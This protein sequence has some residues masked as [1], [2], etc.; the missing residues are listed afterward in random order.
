MKTKTTLYAIFL[1]ACLSC[2]KTA[3][4]LKGPS[5]DSAKVLTYPIN[6]SVTSYTDNAYWFQVTLNEGNYSINVSTTAGVGKIYRGEVYIGSCSTLTLVSTDTLIVPT[7]TEFN[8]GIHNTTGTTTY[9]VKLYNTGESVSFNKTMANAVNIVGQIGFCPGSQ[10]TLSA[11]VTNINGTPTYTWQPGGANSS[12]ISFTPTNILT[13]TLYT[14]TY[15]DAGGTKTATVNI[16]PL[17]PDECKNCEQVQN[18]HFEWYDGYSTNFSNIADSYYWNNANGVG[19]SDYF[20]SNFTAYWVGVPVNYFTTNTPAYNG[21]GYAGFAMFSNV[22]NTREYIQSPL[23]CALVPGQVYN[24]SFYTNLAQIAS[25]ASNNIGAYLSSTPVYTANGSYLNYTP[26]VNSSSIINYSAS[27]TQ[28]SGTMTGNNEQYITLGNFY[29]DAATSSANSTSTNSISAFGA[30]SYYFVDDVSVTPVPPT[31]FS[32]SDTVACNCAS[33]ITLTATG[34]P[35]VYTSWTNGTTTYTGSV[36]SIYCP[37]VTT[38]YTCSVSLPCSNCAPITNTITVWVAPTPTVTA[39]ASPTSICSGSTSTLTA[40]GASTYTWNTGATTST[41]AVSPTVTTIYTVTGTNTLG[42]TATGT[43]MVTVNSSYCCQSP[44]KTFTTGTWSSQTASTTVGA[45]LISVTGVLTINV[46]TTF[47][48]T[49]IRMAPNAKIIIDAGR[50]VNFNSAHLFSCDY[51]WEGIEVSNNSTLNFNRAILTSINPTLDDANIGV[52]S[53]ASAMGTPAVISLNYVELSKNHIGVKVEDYA[54]TSAYPFT[55]KA[56]TVQGNVATSY[57]PGS[58]LKTYLAPSPV[59]YASTEYGVLLEDVNAAIVGS[60]NGGRN[61]FKSLLNG[62]RLLRSNAHVLRNDFLD[63]NRGY[64]NKAIWAA[65]DNALSPAIVSPANAGYGTKHRFRVGTGTSNHCT[66]NNLKYGV[67]SDSCMT[68][69]IENNDFKDINDFG[70]AVYRANFYRGLKVTPVQ[71]GAFYDRDTS[72][73]YNNTMSPNASGSNLMQNGT[74]YFDNSYLFGWVTTNTIS[75]KPSGGLLSEG[76]AIYYGSTNTYAQHLIMDN[77]ITGTGNYGIHQQNMASTFGE[78]ILSNSITVANGSWSPFSLTAGIFSNNSPYAAMEENI[79]DETGI[80]TPTFLT[81]IYINNGQQDY[82]GCNLIKNTSVSC[83][84]NLNNVGSA[85]KGNVMDVAY[86]GL[87]LQNGTMGDIGAAGDAGQNEWYT[88]GMNHTYVTNGV[89]SD[90]YYD[91]SIGARVPTVNGSTAGTPFVPQLTTTGSLGCTQHH[92]GASGAYVM[93]PVPGNENDDQVADLIGGNV[94]FSQYHEGLLWEHQNGILN[95]LKDSLLDNENSTF[96]QFRQ[97]QDNSNMGR[98]N[99]LMRSL[100]DYA[101]V[102]QDKTNY[103]Q[104]LNNINTLTNVVEQNYYLFLSEYINNVAGEPT[105]SD[106]TYSNMQQL[107]QKCPYSDGAVVYN[108][109]GLLKVWGDETLYH[110]SC[111]DFSLPDGGSEKKSNLD[112]DNRQP[113]NALVYPN[114]NNGTFSISYTLKQAIHIFELYDLMGKKVNEKILNGNNG[115]ESMDFS[116]INQGIYFYKI[117]GV[118]GKMLF[119]G[120]LVIHK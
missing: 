60:N 22:L 78:A 76:V 10:I 118:D 39:V 86:T 83:Y 40:S 51:M 58:I 13:P 57:S 65:G 89:G 87:S 46:N 93:E 59:N 109:R 120:K 44:V 26:Q 16:F 35:S 79:I 8:V 114:P 36:I 64:A 74:G 9:Y 97:Q 42:C 3:L 92:K 96:S 20:N 110:N 52:Y 105:I 81:G 111:E 33:S 21:N 56:A 41:I 28:V 99:S 67:Y 30:F 29:S 54:G 1:L 77:T 47:N 2:A 101:A 103:V 82:I 4:A 49:I 14:L 116:S 80:A 108:A 27:W 43:V 113:E 34:S 45:I 17:G 70:I 50:T 73:I 66:F 61:T 98:I 24:V 119:S 85:F 88:I 12:S 117:I 69:Y 104:E 100:G 19:T 91:Y 15:H 72:Y 7:D 102:V 32:S 68:S 5:C 23:K 31:L 62:V 71:I 48:H 38:T 11:Y 90:L 94:T 106:G 6:N 63:L 84:V 18:G 53:D 25:K 107:A 95:L 37:S 75:L 112:P 55:M 115:V